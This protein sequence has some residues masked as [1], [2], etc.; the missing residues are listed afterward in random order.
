LITLYWNLLP[1]AA[2]M[3][4]IRTDQPAR[5]PD[6]Y[7]PIAAYGAIGDGRTVAL[8]G[9][10]GSIDWLCLPEIDSPSVFAAL[11]DSS[12]G[13][14][15]R[16]SPALPFAAQR[17]YLPETNLLE[18]TFTTSAG[19]VR[20]TDCMNLPL[21]GLPPTREL[22][23]Q[24]EGLEGAVPMSWEA[25][26]RFDFAEAKP[27][28]RWRGPVPV[29]T[30]GALALAFCSW[31]AGEPTIDRGAIRAGFTIAAG[32][33]ALLALSVADG[34]PLVLPSRDEVASRLR[35][36]QVYWRGWAA[37]RHHDGPWRD[38]VLRSALAL[39]LLIFA[40]SGAIA[41]AAT[42]SLPE[43]LGGARN[44]DYRFSWVRDAS[45]TLDALLRLGCGGES[46]AFFWWLMHASQLTHPELRVLY[47]LNGG[48]PPSERDL[49]LEGYRGS[50]PARAGNSAAD[51][52]QL[53]IYGHVLQTAWLYVKGGGELHGDAGRRVAGIADLVCE[54][55]READSGI[56]E[57]RSEPTHFTESKMM[58]WIALERAQRLA[59]RGAIPG[60]N[61]RRWGREA[62]ALREF[63]SERCW[64]DR[65][66]AYLRAAGRDEPDASL[67]LPA[68]LGYGGPEE[69]DRLLRTVSWI[70]ERLGEGPLLYRYRGE[71]GLEEGEGAF[72][73]CSF[74]MVDALARLGRQE[75]ARELMEELLP[76]ANDLGLFAEEIDPRSGEQLGN[77]PQGLVHLALI[78]AAHTLEE[79]RG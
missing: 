67:L 30:D 27:R 47:G 43:A 28:L 54:R 53:D 59:E 68:M 32:E 18:T 12:R 37:G 23:R 51:Q 25:R 56:W 44:W 15:F 72:L 3:G 31:S 78:N 7:L 35:A 79:A 62:E 26:P 22:A 65:H 34:D 9:I 16:L 41:A 42:S 13:G 71:D 63:I 66:G 64:S 61:A 74:W 38:A 10:D 76:H 73:A 57:V 69:R 77:V 20:V 17:R 46:E 24:V 6:G 55:W 45:A 36:S 75:D 11:L 60:G 1:S 70:R 2:V 58:C 49:A 33:H 14:S 29:A 4:P 21:A 19:R 5:T 8:V 50:L 48:S 40:P 39:K 52:K